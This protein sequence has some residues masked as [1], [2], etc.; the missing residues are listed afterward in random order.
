[1]GRL[2]IG[3]GNSLRADDG[4]GPIVADL[5]RE[6]LEAAQ[7][8]ACHQ[9]TPELADDVARADRVVFVDAN[10]EAAPGEVRVTRVAPAV[11][12]AATFHSLDHAGLLALARALYG[13]VPPAS[14]VSVGVAD[15]SDGEG[16]SAAVQA[17]LPTLVGLVCLEAKA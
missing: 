17:S 2:V 10:L 11:N 13:R 3:V 15:L 4:V 8:I 1:M 5:A 6:R 14:L 9:L 16:L 12:D 7:V